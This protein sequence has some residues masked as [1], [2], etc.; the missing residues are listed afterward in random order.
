MF[1]LKKVQVNLDTTDTLIGKGSAFEGS[2][3]SEAGIRVEGK[4]KG[5]IDIKGDVVIG[6]D[7]EAISNITARNVTIA[8][9]VRGDINLTGKCTITS[10]GQLIG[11]CTA[12]ALVIEEGGRFDGSSK[13]LQNNKQPAKQEAAAAK[14]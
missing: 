10:K 3:H 13:M 7:G 6:E 1:G 9:I 2:V 4:L 8:G 14:A 5:L 11:N 12:S